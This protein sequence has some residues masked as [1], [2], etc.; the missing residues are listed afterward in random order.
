MK[1]THIHFQWSDKQPQIRFG[2]GVSLHSH[3]LHSRESLDFI[4]RIAR[5]CAPAGWALRHGEARYEL[6][7]GIPLDLRR[8][9]WTPP[10]APRDAHSVESDQISALGLVPIV[11]LTDHDNIEAPMSLQALEGFGNVPISVEWT[12]PFRNTFFHLGVHNIPPSGARATMDR[13]KAFTERPL[14]CEL[15]SILADLHAEPGT[16]TIFNHPLWDEKGIG[17]EQHQAAVAAL[18]SQYGEYLHAVEL[19][20]LRPWKENSAVIRLARDWAK[21]AISGGDRH[22]LEPNA[23]LNL[24]NARDFA[25]FAD[26]VRDGW[27]DVLVTSH[28]RTSHAAR[29]FH[30][31]VDVLRTYENHRLGWT[32]WADRVFYT[33]QDGTIASLAQLWGNHPPLAVGFFTGFMQLA[34]QPTL[35]YALRAAASGAEQVVL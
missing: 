13:L 23:T 21:P 9:W 28:Y 11:S 24:T 27:S 7:H 4:Y 20:G 10:L 2:T 25:E 26:E 3:T 33:L 29:I 18:L 6:L 16:L 22:A 8:A 34:G 12:I 1:E 32:D 5:H 31:I 14:E 35:R 17:S 19:N 15:W 30:N